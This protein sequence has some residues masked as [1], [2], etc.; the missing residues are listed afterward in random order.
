MQLAAATA[1]WAR[2]RGGQRP[3]STAWLRLWNETEANAEESKCGAADLAGCVRTE[4]GEASPRGRESETDCVRHTR[5]ASSVPAAPS[6]DLPLVLQVLGVRAGGVAALGT[7][8]RAE[9]PCQPLEEVAGG[10][11]C[12]QLIRRGHCRERVATCSL[13]TQPWGRVPQPGR[14]V[15]T[16]RFPAVAPR[17]ATPKLGLGFLSFKVGGPGRPWLSLDAGVPLRCGP[18]MG[19]GLGRQAQGEQLLGAPRSPT[20]A[21]EAR[22]VSGDLLPVVSGWVLVSDAVPSGKVPVGAAGPHSPGAQG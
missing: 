22:D 13:V 20:P 7:V 12:P 2:P 9:S 6:D 19:S 16:P 14:G 5:P 3:C 15:W 11:H 10:A 21:C 4:A 8:G 17:H 18:G 1:P